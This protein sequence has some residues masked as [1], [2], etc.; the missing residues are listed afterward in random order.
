MSYFNSMDYLCNICERYKNHIGTSKSEPHQTCICSIF[1]L[2]SVC[3][4][5][6]YETL[7]IE[8]PCLLKHIKHIPNSLYHT[9]I[10]YISYKKPLIT[11]K[12]E[13]DIYQNCVEIMSRV[14]KMKINEFLK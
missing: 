10:I 3:C 13:D 2:G 4:A 11:S 1:N 9:R 5:F 6:G 14:E 7:L 8:N 12:Y